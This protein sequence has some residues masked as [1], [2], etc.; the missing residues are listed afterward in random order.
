MGENKE[1]VGINPQNDT[2]AEEFT[3]PTGGPFAQCCEQDHDI[4][5]VRQHLQSMHAM[6]SESN[7][8]ADS[9]V[10]LLEFSK[11]FLRVVWIVMTLDSVFVYESTA[12][13]YL[14]QLI[15]ELNV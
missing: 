11:P 1:P 5:I 12:L 4:E 7:A 10:M 2:D 13:G 3:I 15:F 14:T 9:Y 8:T 6:V